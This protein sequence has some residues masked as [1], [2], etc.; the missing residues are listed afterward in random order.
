ML[1]VALYRYLRILAA[2]RWAL[3]R[4]C[5]CSCTPCVFCSVFFP[6]VTIKRQLFD[7]RLRSNNYCIDILSYIIKSKFVWL[8]FNRV[9]FQEK[10]KWNLFETVRK[11]FKQSS[12]QL[13][14]NSDLVS[15]IL[16][17]RT[18]R[19]SGGGRRLFGQ[20]GSKVKFQ[21]R[22]S[23]WY[24]IAWEQCVQMTLGKLILNYLI[25]SNQNK[26]V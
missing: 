20:K 13:F 17:Q 25:K 7:L 8:I 23:T 19:G 12:V 5:L 2:R 1:F 14:I 16:I 9:V 4:R 22:C 18:C 11:Q 21:I 24:S 26:L 15:S 6:N 3:I 10:L